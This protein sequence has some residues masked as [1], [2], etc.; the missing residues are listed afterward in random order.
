MPKA[1]Q[2]KGHRGFLCENMSIQR[3]L[4]I[5]KSGYCVK[6]LEPYPDLMIWPKYEDMDGACKLIDAVIDENVPAM[7]QYIAQFPEYN[8]GLDDYIKKCKS[9]GNVRVI[10]N[11]KSIAYN[12]GIS[13]DIFTEKTTDGRIQ[14]K[15]AIKRGNKVLATKTLAKKALPHGKA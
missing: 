14:L 13:M 12:H 4:K 2:R 6:T 3:I 7:Q 15:A 5:R 1:W 9:F 8:L 11:I 10:K